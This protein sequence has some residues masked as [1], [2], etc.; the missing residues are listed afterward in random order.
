VAGLPDGIFFIPEI[1]ITG[2]P[3]GTFSKQK[4]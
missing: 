1:A 3:D 2:T 4:S